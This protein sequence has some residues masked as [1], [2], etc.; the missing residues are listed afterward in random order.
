[1]SRRL[2]NL[3]SRF[4]GHKFWALPGGGAPDGYNWTTGR[5][6]SISDDF[7]SDLAV[8]CAQILSIDWWVPGVMMDNWAWFVYSTQPQEMT[9]DQLSGAAG[10]VDLMIRVWGSFSVFAPLVFVPGMQFWWSIVDFHLLLG[11]RFACLSV[12]VFAIQNPPVC[13]F[14]ST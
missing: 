9:A 7:E 6:S 10:Y 3:I 14:S 1:M 11:C 12:F 5:D 2:S 13:V 4:F 8:F